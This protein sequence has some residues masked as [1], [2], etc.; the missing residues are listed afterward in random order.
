M[1]RRDD[2][3]G[4]PET[5]PY[6]DS[7]IRFIEENTEEN[8]NYTS[9][10]ADL[11]KIRSFNSDLRSVANYFFHEKEQLESDFDYEINAKD[12]EIKDLE[13]KISE[14]R[15]DIRDLMDTIDYLNSRIED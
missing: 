12:D 3:T 13:S 6:I 4:V 5:C 10:I 2:Y 8:T 9:A 1:G 7:V 15:S 14:L 11:E